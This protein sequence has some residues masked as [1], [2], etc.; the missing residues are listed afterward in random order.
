MTSTSWTSLPTE[1]KLQILSHI[2]R[3]LAAAYLKDFQYNVDLHNHGHLPLAE[4]LIDLGQYA[5]RL[6]KLTIIMADI[7]HEMR[8]FWDGAIRKSVAQMHL[9]RCE[10]GDD[11][12][13]IGY[14]LPI[15]RLRLSS[16]VKE[17]PIELDEVPVLVLRNVSASSEIALDF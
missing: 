15:L 6:Q 8:I 10:C 12:H 2:I 5:K 3:N 11:P 9:Y 4:Q 14:P 16:I 7:R 17:L 1:L 13:S